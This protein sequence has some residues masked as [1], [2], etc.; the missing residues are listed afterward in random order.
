MKEAARSVKQRKILFTVLACA[1]VCSSTA[2]ILVYANKG[3]PSVQPT[4]YVQAAK[5]ALAQQIAYLP[6]S[7]RGIPGMK[8]VA[9]TQELGL[10]LQPDTTEVAVLD[11]RSGKV[12]YSNP[13]DRNEDPV[14]SPFEKDVLS[15]QLTISFRDDQATL[16]SYSNY[17]QSIGKKQFKVES[18]EK[19]IRITYTLGDMSLGID[20]LPKYITEQRLQEKVLSKLDASTARYVQSRYYPAKGKRGV[21]ERLDGQISKQLVLNKML[22][23]FEKAGY[24]KQDLEQDNKENGGSSGGVSTK[25]N[26]VIPLEYRLDGDSLVV[27]V[28]VGQIKESVKHKISNLDLLGY[29]G[30]AGTREEGYMFVPDGTGSLIYLNNGKIKEE[31]YVQEVYGTDLT[32]NSRNR[33]QVTESARMPVFGMKS[34]DSAWLAVIEKGDGIASINADISGKQNSYNHVY[35]SFAVRGEDGLELY[36]GQKVQDIQLL[37]DSLY[38]GDIQVRYSFLYKEQANYAGMAQVYQQ[39]LVQEKVLTPLVQQEH[40]PLYLDILGAVDKQKTF[41]GFPYRSVIPMTTF[42]Q[43]GEIAGKLNKDGISNLQL[44]YVGWFGKGVNHETAVKVAPEAILGGKS[45]LKALNSQLGASGGQLYPDVAFQQIYHDDSH[46]SPASDAS[47][48]ITKEDAKRSPF[49]RALNRMDPD[50]GSYYLL[51]PTKLPFYVGKFIGKYDDLGIQ[52]LSLRDLGDLLNSDYRSSR[53]VYRDTAKNMVSEQLDRLKGQFPR[54]MISGGNAFAWKSAGH[55]INAPMSSS[56]FNITD[57]EIPFYQMVLHGYVDYTGEPVNLAEDQDVHKHLLRIVEMGASPHF[58]WSYEPSST[59]KFTQYDALYS[60]S[61][62]DWYSQAIEMYT[63]ADQVLSGLRTQPITGRRTLQ[64]GVVEVQYANGAS[65]IVNY[66][67]KPVSV[68]G[69]TVGAQDFRVGGDHS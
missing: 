16:D 6:E 23:A 60:T 41:L 13:Q 5:P 29:F 30:A 40:I 20:A 69:V 61:Y 51:S 1:A 3:A 2:G 62:Q 57:E 18:I 68:G 63:K 17:A 7:N 12:W 56:G 43:A 34:G 54:I 65:V 25:P 15:S 39:R 53:V 21:L 50:L 45:G 14:A 24:T 42:A 58:L 46:F 37:S 31:K 33:G 26:F 49:N 22:E 44:R 19:G 36:T 52:G 59:L 35:G 11:K 55:V 28:P 64:D 38:P 48:F 4:A 8:L 47:R 32:T 9:D 66:T 27:S 67:K 10:Y